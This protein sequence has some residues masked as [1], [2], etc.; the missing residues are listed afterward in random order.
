[1]PLETGDLVYS[2]YG[3]GRLIRLNHDDALIQYFD[4]P[5]NYEGI[6]QTF[7]IKYLKKVELYA[8]SLVYRYDYELAHWQMARVVGVI[9]GGVRLHFPNKQQEDVSLNDIFVRWDR[10]IRDAAALLSERITYTPFWQDARLA[11]QHQMLKQRNACA[12]ITSALSSSIE[13]E[14][15]QLAVARRVLSD[16]IQR[17]LLADE[18]GLGKTIEAGL[19]VRQH[20]TEN[21]FTHCVV[22][23]A[24]KVLHRQWQQELSAR[25]HL[26][27]LLNESVH[28]I[29]MADFSAENPLP[30]RPDMLVIDE[31]HQVGAWA[32]DADHEQ[33][34]AS[35]NHLAQQSEKLLLLSATPVTGNEKNFLAMLHLLDAKNYPLTDTGLQKFQQ[36]ILKREE[37]GSLF[38]AFN[39]DNDNMTL[40]ENLEALTR[41]F[42]EDEI[43]NGLATQLLPHLDMM[44]S[45]QRTETRDLLINKI[46]HYIGNRYRLHHR[47]LRNRR[48]NPGISLLMPGLSGLSLKKYTTVNSSNDMMI[49]WRESAVMMHPQNPMLAATYQLLFEAAI[50]TPELLAQL[51]TC[52]LQQ[53]LLSAAQGFLYSESQLALLQHPLFEGEQEILLELI[54]R[55]NMERDSKRQ[56]LTEVLETLLDSNAR[57]LPYIVVFCDQPWVADQVF[58]DLMMPFIGKIQRHN[59]DKEVRFGRG[60]KCQI[61]VCDRRAE[62]GVNL[63]GGR[64]I[65]LHY[66]L[67]LSPNRME[68]RLGRLNRYCANE[69]A[70]TILSMALVSET[71]DL[72]NQWLNILNEVFDVFEESIASLQYLVDEELQWLKD[73]LYPLGEEG[74]MQLSARLAGENGLLVLEKQRVEMQEV[75]L[76]IDGD[77]IEAREYADALAEIDENEDE[78]RFCARNLVEKVLKFDFTPDEEIPGAFRYRFN[79]GDW[80]TGTLVSSRRLTK[81]CLLGFDLSKSGASSPVTWPLSYNRADTTQG[82]IRPARLGEPFHDAILRLLDFEERGI[83]SAVLRITSG[84][85]DEQKIFFRYDFLIEAD[86]NTPTQQRLADYLMPPE[87]MT[88]W[89]NQIGESIADTDVLTILNEPYF[90]KDR[91]GKHLN[92]NEQRWA[93]IAHCI[94]AKEWRTTCQDSYSFALK[95]AVERFASQQ[96]LSLS[97]LEHYLSSAALHHSDQQDIGQTLRQGIAQPK[98]TCLATRALLIASEAILHKVSQ[99]G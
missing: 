17:Y 92:L 76:Q 20:V 64:K 38:Y 48:S 40:E 6:E 93:Q 25:F 18:V 50:A 21:Q 29:D 80:A 3:I 58:T 63:H 67:L 19:I 68:Q 96:T 57:E 35:V 81:H 14:P 39:S 34:Y 95:L 33:Q 61:L 65:A 94:S 2:P 86:V 75:L 42:P 89:L 15:Y 45:Q 59:P 66:D 44:L 79:P 98:I 27:E 52:R 54:D 74:M 23:V 9:P 41:L 88:L 73:H 77:I 4:S 56:R 70:T 49:A 5:A 72:Q 11:Y 32:W 82:K 91:G 7:E 97:R 53:Q 87:T 90:P 26:E 84:M 60:S 22:I 78:F 71:E 16:P 36:R 37:I 85:G 31:A 8:E 62:E 12:G 43:L 99:N 46:R 69:N 10:P 30:F 83:S 24:P 55:C 47:L 1:M 51:A 13:L 28:I